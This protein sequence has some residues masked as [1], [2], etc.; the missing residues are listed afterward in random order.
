MSVYKKLQ[1]ARV[2]LHKTQLNKSGKNKFAGYEYFELGD[3]LPQI[4]KICKDIGL[5]GVVSFDNSMAYLQINDTEIPSI[6]PH[7]D[8]IRNDI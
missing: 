1:E 2:I 3:F 5:C 8:D 4:Q 7:T 6:K